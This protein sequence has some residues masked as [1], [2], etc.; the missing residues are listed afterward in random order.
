MDTNINNKDSEDQ[1]ASNEC[2]EYWEKEKQIKFSIATEDDVKEMQYMFKNDFLPDEP[3]LGNCG[4]NFKE[5]NNNGWFHRKME[6][7]WDKELIGDPVTKYDH[8]QSCIIARS[9]VTGNLIGL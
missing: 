9:T 3:V 8:A 4:H 2:D 1:K 6:K 7:E 5:G